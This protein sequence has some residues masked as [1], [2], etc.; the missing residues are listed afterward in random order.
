MLVAC[1]GAEVY[2]WH[3]APIYCICAVGVIQTEVAKTKNHTSD[4]VCCNNV[5]ILLSV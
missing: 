1:V 2:P 4:S 3:K 5:Q